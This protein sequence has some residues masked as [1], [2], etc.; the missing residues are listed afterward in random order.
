MSVPSRASSSLRGAFPGRKPGTR[1]SR[2]S[3][4]KAASIAR[5]NSPAGTVTRSL[6]LLPST[7]STVLCIRREG[8]VSRAFASPGPLRL[9]CELR[10][11]ISRQREGTFRAFASAPDRTL[12]GVVD[13]R[14]RVAVVT[15]AGRGIGRAYALRMAAYGARVVVND[16]GVATD[17]SS[18]DEDPAAEVVGE[19]MAAGGDAI[20]QR[21]D[22]ADATVGDA[23]V[24]AALDRWG[25][26]DIVVNN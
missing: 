24:A 9:G 25:R 1:T 4:R 10:P 14:E 11:S 2:A 13:L 18:T 12:A 20:A 16:A 3:L 19:I 22:I 8:S 21:G 23:L 15:G 5:S 6:T 7:D 26:L 17:G